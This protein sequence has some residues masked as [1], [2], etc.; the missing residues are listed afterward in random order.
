MNLLPPAT[1]N[2]E[3]TH[4]NSKDFM[5]RRKKIIFTK[6]FMEKAILKG[7]FDE[8]GFGN[9][10]SI[11][12]E[13]LKHSGVIIPDKDGF[14]C[15]FPLP[16]QRLITVPVVEEK[17]V[18]VAKTIFFSQRPDIDEYERIKNLRNGGQL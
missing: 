18:I 3:Y 9:G 14:K 10:K 4:E 11:T 12:E 17:E 5:E 8:C 16:N 6:H 13:A 15:I 2:L 1:V 7:I